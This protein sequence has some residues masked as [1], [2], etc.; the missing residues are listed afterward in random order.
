[1]SNGEENMKNAL[2]AMVVSLV[3]ALTLSACQTTKEAA[4]LPPSEPMAPAA[5][6]Q[7]YKAGDTFV[8]LWS[9]GENVNVEVISAD[10]DSYTFQNA[11]SKCANTRSRQLDFYAPIKG[12]NCSYGSITREIS[13]IKGSL[14]PLKVGNTTSFD[15]K[16]TFNGSRTYNASC[17]VTTEAHLSLPYGED[18]VYQVVCKDGIHNITSYY[19][20]AKQA[21]VKYRF[22][23]LNRSEPYVDYEVVSIN[24]K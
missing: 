4:M 5:M 1:M 2:S 17:E 11:G 12:E 20:P 18:D 16:I 22:L 10:E 13:N 3:G 6:P 8:T 7:S 14:W 15:V 19:S 24:R 21:V 9:S 23:R